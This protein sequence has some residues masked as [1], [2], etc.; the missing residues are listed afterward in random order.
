VSLFCGVGFL[1]PLI[2]YLVKRESSI[3]L[4][5]HAR[6]VLNFHISLFVYCLVTF[7]FVFILIGIPIY[8]LIG[9]TALICSIIGAMRASDGLLY[10]YPLT[11]RLV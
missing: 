8:I 4:A 5:A 2:V 6:E 10:H 7:P 9:L 3:Y 1:L 11:F